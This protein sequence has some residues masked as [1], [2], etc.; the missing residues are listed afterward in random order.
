MCAAQRLAGKVSIITGGAAGIGKAVCE[1]F[2]QEGAS[3]VV[4]DYNRAGA[5][6]VAAAI[7]TAGGRAMALQADVTDK[8]QVDAMVTKT[9]QAF[10]RL[11]VI[12][13][14]AGIIQV[15]ALLDLTEED[16]DRV[17]AVNLKGTL[18][19][20]QAAARQMIAQGTGGR[21][22]CTASAAARRPNPYF[23]HYSAS[24]GAVVNLV[25]ASALALAPH[26]ITVNSVCPGIVATAMWEHIDKVISAQEGLP[27]G[28]AIRR[29]LEGVPLRRVQEPE[30]VAGLVAFL[31]SDDAAYITGQAYNVTG[32]MV[33]T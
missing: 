24:K 8:T 15:K 19:G 20:I 27:V 12:H 33:M 28:E 3:V 23:A 11:D 16:W 17:Q 31:A 25:Q 10:G 7:E 26:N 14:N 5:E 18:F 6:A 21:I 13:N 30:D 4:A 1:R 2:G 9:V 22:I 32:G 29:R